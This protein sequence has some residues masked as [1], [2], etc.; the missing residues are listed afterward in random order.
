[1]HLHIGQ[2]FDLD[3]ERSIWCTADVETA[4]NIDVHCSVDWVVPSAGLLRLTVRAVVG[5]AERLA[6]Q[7]WGPTAGTSYRCA[8]H[9]AVPYQAHQ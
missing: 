5:Q 9:D 1:M 3:A 2:P 6:M 7:A 8:I 4:P